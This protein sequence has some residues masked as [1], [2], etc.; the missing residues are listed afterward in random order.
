MDQHTSQR[1]SVDQPS[2]ML[3]PVAGSSFSPSTLRDYLNRLTLE[4]VALRVGLVC[5]N[6]AHGAEGC[7]LGL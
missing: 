3:M 6:D 2:L 1:I 5:T 4:T 7:P